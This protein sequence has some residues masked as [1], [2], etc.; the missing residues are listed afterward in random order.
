MP[1]RPGTAAA[2]AAPDGTALLAAT[3]DRMRGAL[4]HFASG[5]TVVT[6]ATEGPDG[7]HAHGM[8]ANAFTSVS[9]EPP[10]VLVSIST[11]ARSH[12]RIDDSGRYGVSILGA[13]QGPVAHHFA[14][15]AQSPEAVSLEW[16]DGLPLVGGA[17]VHL[18]CRVR[19]SHRAGDHT[20]FV[21]EVEGLWLGS[22]G[23]LV[24]Y[25]RDLRALAGPAPTPAGDPGAVSARDQAPAPAPVPTQAPAAAPVPDRA[26][27]RTPEPTAVREHAPHQAPAPAPVP[28][29]AP[30]PRR[31]PNPGTDR[32]ERPAH[33]R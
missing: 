5:V 2:A 22:G 32:E 27:A 13:E 15:G 29:Q 25:R 14:G 1:D 31:D 7:P 3:P 30:G 23:P 9:L 21:G 11:R 8:T 6:T 28:H 18:A 4:G 26:P 17:L 33:A 20:L 10:L 24:H 19:Q 12:R 16:R